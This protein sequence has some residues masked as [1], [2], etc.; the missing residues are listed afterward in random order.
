M[1]EWCVCRDLA[2]DYYFLDEE[3]YQVTGQRTGNQYKLGDK[4]KIRV[5]KIDVSRKEMDFQII[6]EEPGQGFRGQKKVLSIFHLTW[7]VNSTDRPDPTTGVSIKL[8]KNDHSSPIFLFFAN[9]LGNDQCEDIPDGEND[10]EP[11]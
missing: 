1:K 9:L 2:D 11:E 7:S 10:A 3:N 6:N 4:V 8:R 5:K